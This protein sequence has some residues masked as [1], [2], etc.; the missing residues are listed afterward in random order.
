MNT[1]TAFPN[2]YA[3]RTGPPAGCPNPVRAALYGRR[4]RVVCK[5]Q[6]NSVLLEFEDGARVVASLNAVRKAAQCA[7][8]RGQ[9]DAPP[10]TD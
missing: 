1:P 10:V 2:V 8:E 4:C 3:F 5:G 9:G 7:G 6:M